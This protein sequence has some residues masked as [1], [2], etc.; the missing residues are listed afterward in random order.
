MHPLVSICIP[1]YDRADLLDYTLERL[2]PI[3]DC[4][5]PVEIVI[6]DNGSADHTPAMIASHIARN[7]L[8]RAF[9]MPE[10]RSAGANWLNAFWKA[11]GELMVYLADD[12]SLIFDNLFQHFSRLE[13]DKDLVA[14]FTDWIAWDDQAEQEIHRHYAGLT[15]FTSFESTAPLSLINFMLQRFY[16]PEIGVYRREALIRAHSF[17]SRSL[18]YYLNMY[19]LSRIGRIAFDPLPF[20]REHRI[21]KDRFQRTHWANMAMQFHMIG[22]ELRLALEE[23]VLMAVQDEGASYLPPDQGQVVMQSIERILHSRLALEID[24]ACGRKDWIMAIELRR[25][26]VLWHGPGE[27]ADASS[28]VLKLVIP[29]AFQSMV[30]TYRSISGAAGLSLRGFES[31]QAREFLATFFA[32]VPLL[33]AGPANGS[34]LIVHRD[35]HTLAADAD[36]GDPTTVLVMQRLLDLYRIDKSRI[37]L[38]GF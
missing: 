12:D 10:N 20:Y 38:K 33:P 16:P 18:P 26:F 19:R 1:T 17:H 14:I 2:S 9:R 3:K 6:S 30:Q 32:D 25:R 4:G 5:W 24:R 34:A 36:A 31:D 35:E 29:A 27:T 22:D 11:K 28:D 13:R 37:D 21:L 15:E 8:I 23:M 7:P